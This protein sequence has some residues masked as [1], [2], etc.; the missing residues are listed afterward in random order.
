MTTYAFKP[1]LLDLLRKAQ[2]E[3]NAFFQELPPAELQIVGEPDFWS[4]KDHVAH[5]TFWRRRLVQRLT[6]I[7]QGQELPP[8]AQSY[9]QLNPIIF[10]EQRERPW[11]AIHAESEQ[12]YAE[13]L[14]L[15]EQLSDDELT[16]PGRFNWINEGE[17]LYIAFMGNCYEHTQEHLTQYYLDRHDLPRATQIREAWVERVMQSAAPE[18]LK[19]TVLYNLACFYALHGQ[20][21]KAAT[22]LEKSLA[23]APRLKEWSLSDPDLDALHAQSA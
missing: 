22:L 3:Q 10:A 13:L 16:L 1:V 17:P 20:L 11:S 6:A 14:K 4:A 5:L 18:D 19:G 2:S 23:L 21:E 8:D 12:V 7:L 15:T 9:E